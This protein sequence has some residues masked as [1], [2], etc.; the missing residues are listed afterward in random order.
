MNVYITIH[1][2]LLRYTSQTEIN[3]NHVDSLFRYLKA[4]KWQWMT[5]ELFRN[6]VFNQKIA[7]SHG[8]QQGFVGHCQLE[9]GVWLKLDVSASP[10]NERCPQLPLQNTMQDFRISQNI[11]LRFVINEWYWMMLYFIFW[12]L[13]NIFEHNMFTL[14]SLLCWP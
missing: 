10:S 1:K 12:K 6:M 4:W 8:S 13:L 3:W 7:T 9:P 11:P 2:H 14:P 5:M